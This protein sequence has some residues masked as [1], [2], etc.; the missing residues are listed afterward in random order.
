[1]LCF[2]I[3]DHVTL[4]QGIASFKHR[5]MHVQMSYEKTYEK[6]NKRKIPS[7]GLKWENK[8]YEPKRSFHTYIAHFLENFNFLI[9]KSLS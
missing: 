8:M 7:C 9:P 1:M 2:A 6:K 3:S 5:L 4:L